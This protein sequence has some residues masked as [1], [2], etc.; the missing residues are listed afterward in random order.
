MKHG[1]ANE[2]ALKIS[3]TAEYDATIPPTNPKTA[4]VMQVIFVQ[5]LTFL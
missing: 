4:I 2:P 5:M 3:V 1:F